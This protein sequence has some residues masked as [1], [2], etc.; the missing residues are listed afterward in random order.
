LIHL[1]LIQIGM[2]L[3]WVEGSEKRLKQT[4]SKLKDAH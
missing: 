4:S 2:V 3:V 1:G